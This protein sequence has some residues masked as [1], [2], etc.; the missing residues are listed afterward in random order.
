MSAAAA[1]CSGDCQGDLCCAVGVFTRAQLAVQLV[2]AKFGSDFVPPKAT[3]IFA[4]LSTNHWAAPYA[5]YLYREGVV[6]GCDS[7]NF[8][9]DQ[10]MKRSELAE[11]VLKAAYG[12]RYQPSKASGLFFD[13]NKADPKSDFSEDLAKRNAIEGC[14]ADMFCPNEK[15][16]KGEALQAL[17]ATFNAQPACRL[18]VA[19]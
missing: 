13:L 3:G 11:P 5:E 2:A 7:R 12:S 17:N 9:A 10:A 14:A 16:Q 18:G 4:D 15:L 8:C 1:G 19:P 6:F